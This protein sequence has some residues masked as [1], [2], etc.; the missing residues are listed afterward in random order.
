[1]SGFRKALSSLSNRIEFLKTLS[2][3]HKGGQQVTIPGPGRIDAFGNARRL[4][5]KNAPKIRLNAPVSFPHLWGLGQLQWFHWDGNTNSFMERNIGQAMG[6]GAIADLETGASTISP[7]NIHT[8]ESLYSR[9]APPAWPEDHFGAVDTASQ[10]Y[11]RGAALFVQHCA[12]CHDR[13]EGG[14]KGPDGSIT[15]GLAEIGTDPLRA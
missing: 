9:L 2:S 12:Q 14:Q 10:R 3:L 4:V 5:F 8:L 15:Y 7:L 6:L 1:M 13:Q 11:R